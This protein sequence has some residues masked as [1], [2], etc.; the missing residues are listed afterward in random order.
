MAV[1]DWL[2]LERSYQY[3]KDHSAQASSIARQLGFAGIAIIWVLR[4]P[5]DGGPFHLSNNLSWA[6]L[7]IIICLSFD[8][9]Q[10]VSASI[11]W[12]LFFRKKERAGVSE[13]DKFLAPACINYPAYFFFYTKLTAITAGYIC[14]ACHVSSMLASLNNLFL[15]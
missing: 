12:H 10:Y 6:A 2:T 13:N 15:C 3:A 14:L 5:N 1:K 11:L 4:S 8:F 7:F 9:F